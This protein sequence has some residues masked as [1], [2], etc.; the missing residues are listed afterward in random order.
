[1][2]RKPKLLNQSDLS[3]GSLIGKVLCCLIVLELLVALAHIV[4]SPLIMT[5]WAS[6]AALIL[7][8]RDAPA[9]RPIAVLMGHLVSSLV[10]TAFLLAGPSIWWIGPAVALSFALMAGLGVLHPPAAAN[11][12]ILMIT[13]TAPTWFLG[14][15]FVGASALA[16]MAWGLRKCAAERAFDVPRD[17]KG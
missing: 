6:S 3:F 15:T 7:G 17:A 13:P 2:P 14:A 5:S 4:G 11:A 1:M 12:A 16:A 10:A 9:A 8:P